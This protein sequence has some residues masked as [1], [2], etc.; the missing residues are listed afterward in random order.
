LKGD[1]HLARG[2]GDIGAPKAIQVGGRPR[3]LGPS[4]P[5]R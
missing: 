1:V 3:N 5:D 4:F 2:G